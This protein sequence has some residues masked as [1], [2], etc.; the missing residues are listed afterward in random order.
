MSKLDRLT[1]CQRHSD[2]LRAWFGE[3]DDVDVAASHAIR[4]WLERNLRWYWL[5]NDLR[6]TPNPFDERAAEEW[7]TENCQNIAA[8]CPVCHDL[9]PTFLLAR[10]GRA[11]Q[12]TLL[13]AFPYWRVSSC[14][15]P[16]PGLDKGQTA[17]IARL[18]AVE[19]KQQDAPEQWWN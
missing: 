14:V 8:G 18:T 7:L 5:M 15:I 12:E 3:A 13:G 6:G 4:L 9:S 10:A 19:V 16:V 17:Y 11:T 1:M 2:I